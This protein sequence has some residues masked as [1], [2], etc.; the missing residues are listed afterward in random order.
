MCPH[1]KRVQAS[2]LRNSS[3]ALHGPGWWRSTTCKCGCDWGTHI[4]PSLFLS[5]PLSLARMSL[6]LDGHYFSGFCF[7][8]ETSKKI[9]D[10]K[11]HSLPTRRCLLCFLVTP[12]Q[13]SVRARLFAVNYNVPDAWATTPAS[14]PD[15]ACCIHGVAEVSL[16]A[17]GMPRTFV[18]KILI[19][20][21]LAWKSVSFPCPFCL[22]CFRV[23]H[24][25]HGTEH[26]ARASPAE[27]TLPAQ[28][29]LQLP[30]FLACDLLLAPWL[31]FQI[32]LLHLCGIF[33][34][35]ACQKHLIF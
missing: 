18:P 28:L 22:L 29:S 19:S 27:F 24:A 31:S 15:L 10:V 14:L 23:Q 3:N 35:T 26:K 1:P 25:E 30:S 21:E 9:I 34:I 5:R 4:S 33:M 32:V 2:R 12:P 17:F 8:R 7:G 20:F 11:S 6:Q 16:L 13:P